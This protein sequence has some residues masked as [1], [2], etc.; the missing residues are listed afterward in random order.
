MAQSNS[1]PSFIISEV[2]SKCYVKIALQIC[3][4]YVRIM[5]SRLQSFYSTVLYGKNVKTNKRGNNFEK[6]THAESM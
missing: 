2:R 6:Q 5:D 3:N 4:D 1:Y